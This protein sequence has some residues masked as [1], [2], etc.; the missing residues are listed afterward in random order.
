MTLHLIRIGPDGKPADDFTRE[1]FRRDRE[2]W[3]K[4]FAKA[5]NEIFDEPKPEESK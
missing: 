3:E 5:L 2:D 4:A 1:C